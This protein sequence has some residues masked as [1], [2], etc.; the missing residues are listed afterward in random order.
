MLTMTF[1]PPNQK[2]KQVK[3]DQ[4]LGIGYGMKT[5]LDVGKDLSHVVPSPDTYNLSNFVETNK[6]H[7]KG[8]FPGYGRTETTPMSY[9]DL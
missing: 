1:L 4:Y 8:F 7:K 9:I 5:N 6:N 2:E 3:I